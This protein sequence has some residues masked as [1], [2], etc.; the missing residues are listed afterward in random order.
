MSVNFINPFLRAAQSVLATETGATVRRQ[1][2]FLEQ[3]GCTP[4]DVTVLLSIV[5]EIQGIVL[6]SMDIDVALALVSRML[7]QEHKEFDELAQSGIA[8]MGNVITGVATTYLAEA[9]YRCN[10]S[11]PTVILGK[12]T[13][14][15]TVGF[16]RLVV[17][18]ETDLGL[19]T[20]HLA[21][22]NTRQETV[23]TSRANGH[24]AVELGADGPAQ[25]TSSPHA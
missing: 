21:L 16:K 1:A 10:I 6:Y 22:R 7:G 9:G 14:L 12:G 13:Q 20:V 17:P 3:N 2:V 5:G 15:S 18:L 11:V 23:A 4:A 25:A 8:E 24:A 19:I